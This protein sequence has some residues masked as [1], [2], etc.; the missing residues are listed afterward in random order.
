VSILIIYLRTIAYTPFSIPN[1]PFFYLVFRAWSHWRALSGSKHIQFLLDNNLIKPAPSKILDEL[2][3]NG[4]RPFD[5]S[6]MTSS[7]K[8]SPGECTSEQMILHKSD[9]KRIAAALGIPELDVELDRAVWQVEK[10]LKAAQE[11]EEE[12]VKLR[13]VNKKSKEK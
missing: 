1:L 2:Y 10:A 12:A 7:A 8:S 4:K 5:V 9:G 13:K 6:P 11:L 3:A